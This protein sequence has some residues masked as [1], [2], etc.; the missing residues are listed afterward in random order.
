MLS[1]SVAWA[2][3]GTG[4][5]FGVALLLWACGFLSLAL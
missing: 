5:L 4:R 3:L 1:D 2:G